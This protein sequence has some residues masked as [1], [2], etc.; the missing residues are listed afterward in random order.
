MP[1]QTSN[2]HL[3]RHLQ[4]ELEAGVDLLDMAGAEEMIRWPMLQKVNFSTFG[5]YS[6]EVTSLAV[7]KAHQ[8]EDFESQISNEC[9]QALKTFMLR[10]PDVKYGLQRDIGVD[11]WVSLTWTFAG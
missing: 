9:L 5:Y 8:K 1:G 11:V 7:L 6:W 3:V 2:M 4:L 10:R